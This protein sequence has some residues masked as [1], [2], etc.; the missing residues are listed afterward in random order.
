MKLEIFFKVVSLFLCLG[1][2]FT[3]EY[4]GITLK[5]STLRLLQEKSDSDGIYLLSSGAS[6]NSVVVDGI[7]YL[8][9]KVDENKVFFLEL[10]ASLGSLIE[11]TSTANNATNPPSVLII[12]KF[13]NEDGIKEYVVSG[14][15]WMCNE[16][17]ARM[18][19]SRNLSDIAKL[20]KDGSFIWNDFGV[21]KTTCA[22]VIRKQRKSRIVKLTAFANDKLIDFKVG[23]SVYKFRDD[24]VLRMSYVE[25]IVN[26][27]INNGDIIGLT[28][29][30]LGLTPGIGIRAKIE[31]ED[32]FFQKRTYLTNTNEWTCNDQ[33]AF[34]VYDS[35]TTPEM[36]VQLGEAEKIWKQDT[37]GTVFCYFIYKEFTDPRTQINVSVMA[38]KLLELNI[39]SYTY[40]PPVARENNKLI[41][42]TPLVD[43]KD[44]DLILIKVSAEP[45]QYIACALHMNFRDSNGRM[46]TISTNSQDWICNGNKPTIDQTLGKVG[47]GVFIY[48]YFNTTLKY[49][50]CHSVYRKSLS[51]DY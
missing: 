43:L 17:P 33:P 47:D 21:L 3:Q 39:G 29:S 26:N 8:T 35:L 48:F 14:D 27:G 9:S 36:G 19:S 4:S 16:Y 34:A 22:A 44:G 37:Q 38:T 7:E 31:L 6:V 51:V 50:I 20:N 28:A 40:I 23:Q 46:R 30:D 25:L 11:V 2:V 10:K 18:V 13:A 15:D 32:N 12:V 41:N 42:L 49:R 5:N 1:C 24:S 45:N